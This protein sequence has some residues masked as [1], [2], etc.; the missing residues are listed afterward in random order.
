MT[1]LTKE[2]EA[3]IVD[4]MVSYYSKKKNPFATADRAFG[5]LVYTIA[6]C[7]YDMDDISL[8]DV[9]RIVEET[10]QRLVEVE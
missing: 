9:Y 5:E 1:K 10:R 6:A 2:I 8:R 4:R 7:Y 3:Q